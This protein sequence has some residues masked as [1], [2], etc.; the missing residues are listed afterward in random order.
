MRIALACTLGIVMLS[1]C[2]HKRTARRAPAAPR[3]TRNARSTA[4]PAPAPETPRPAASP[5]G[6]APNGPEPLPGAVPA[7]VE[8]G[9]A[10]WYGHPYHG[11]VAANGEVYDMEQ[12][13]AAHRTLP[14]DTMVHVVNLANNKTVDLRITDRGP[15]VDGR[16][17]DVSH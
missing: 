8:T 6:S 16:I 1:G 13:T 10:S 4:P 15:F 12:M 9:L 7:Y 17:I 14:F 5:R 2:A 3:P 11:R